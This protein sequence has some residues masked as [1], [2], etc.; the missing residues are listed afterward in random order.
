MNSQLGNALCKNRILQLGVLT[1][2]LLPAALAQS[3]GSLVGTV[4]DKSGAVVPDAV[5]T[6][7]RPGM[8]DPAD[9]TKTNGA[10]AYTFDS[11]PPET[12]TVEVQ[13]EGFQV[14]RVEAV[15]V[16]PTSE[17]A[18]KVELTPATVAA[19]AS[20]TAAPPAVQT[21]D[22]QVSANVT[23]QQLDEL[24]I[25]NRN[26][27]SLIATQAGVAGDYGG[28]ALYAGTGGPFTTIDG[29]R[30]SFSNVT[31]D[32]INVQDNT[33]RSNGLNIVTTDVV[34][35][36]VSQFTLV[37]SNQLSTYGG[38]V[39]QTAFV[40]Q[41]GT[42]ELH[43][44]L[45]YINGNNL[46]NANDWFQ[47][48]RG[49]H[50]AYKTNQGGFAIGG[51]LV[52]NKLFGYAAYEFRRA[53]DTIGQQDFTLEPG[54]LQALDQLIPGH[55][56]P[57]VQSILQQLPTPNIGVP[58]FFH[59]SQCKSN[60][61]VI[62]YGFF[63]HAEEQAAV[64]DNSTV[65][66]DYVPSAQNTFVG[67]YLWDRANLDLNP[68][69]YGSVFALTQHSKANLISGSWRAMPNSRF[70]NEIR[71]GA[72]ISPLD[73]INREQTAS[74]MLNLGP[75]LNF[76]NP[77][78]FFSG[79]P[80]GR[81]L[82]T[83]ALQDNA[84]YT[85]GSHTVRFG[86]QAQLIRVS[87]YVPIDF[88]GYNSLPTVYLGFDGSG[89]NMDTAAV[90]AGV[91]RGILQNFPPANSSGTLGLGPAK[92]YPTINNLAFYTQDNWKVNRNLTMTLGF[93]YEYY[94]PLI[95]RENLLYSPVLANGSLA[96]TF[97][98]PSTSF[99]SLGGQ[100]YRA[101]QKDF[102]P[103]IGMA[104]D[105]W[106]TGRT[107]VRAS[108]GISYVNDDFA[109]SL[110]LTPSENDLNFISSAG[111]GLLPALN[112]V[113]IPS[114]SVDSAHV[115]G[116]VD[117]AL[118]T[119]YVQQ[120]SFGI[121]HEIAG[122]VLDLRYVGNHA[123]RLLRPNSFFQPCSSA[124][125]GND[126]LV[127]Y[128]SNTSGSRYNALQFD[129]TRRLRSDL[130]FQANYTY[131][132][133]LTDSNTI[134]SIV[135]DPYRDQTNYRLDLG[136]ALFDLRHAFKTNLVY[137]L[138]FGRGRFS[139][140]PLR[141]LLGGWTVSAIAEA[142]SGQ[143]F[144]ILSNADS[145]FF[146]QTADALI[147]GSALNQVVSYHVAGNGPGIISASATTPGQV[148]V[149]PPKGAPGDLQ[150]RSFYGPAWFNL[151][152]GLQKQFRITERQ[153]IEIRAVAVDVLNHPAFG[154]NNQFL[155]AS[156]F[157]LNSYEIHVPRTMQF[158]AYYRF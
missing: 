93:R 40:S 138:P 25:L 97:S 87:E 12:F 80:Q 42:N 114:T 157:G 24:P 35:S 148:F 144:S 68:S 27:L 29:L 28:G 94:T 111:P 76:F 5:V 109:E 67:S 149:M 128:N 23:Q 127:F 52:K 91:Y 60:C 151:D 90:L 4:V 7:Y 65:R 133:V 81:T 82:K 150:P 119:P 38:G 125:P 131:S 22:A 137:E 101:D 158:S 53:H 58:H 96:A 1:I 104:L 132:K 141:S 66:L 92:F 113:P 61:T 17:R 103:S 16:A 51:P 62:S 86:F 136:P 74:S 50:D 88:E 152:L 15:T 8:N 72:V 75:V 19:T 126:N 33:V 10:G 3:T 143:P 156:N 63:Q 99:S 13:K 95:D 146:V 47:N 26:P 36:Q 11:V 48:A 140:M 89:S 117:R 31:L 77:V 121:Q 39:T 79:D 84:S 112:P 147:G 57:A 83:Y 115:V 56:N 145:P 69:V 153:N 70:T 44:Y 100:F 14:A 41:A 30:T 2:I 6:L 118:R 37:T 129:V 106:G 154:F 124:C 18:L 32:G 155:G 110:R 20:V 130:Y 108:Y 123:S 54:Q 105:P 73:F 142:Q 45:F 134:S 59:A 21:S 120:W 71:V 98:A 55:L 43:G 49:L 122:F 78:G 46:T 116:L 9:R 139:S 85:R 102:A 34:A 64:T 107:V 135:V